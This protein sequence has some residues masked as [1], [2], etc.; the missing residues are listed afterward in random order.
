MGPQQMH[1][2]IDFSLKPYDVFLK[3]AYWRQHFTAGPTSP[4]SRWFIFSP[5]FVYILECAQSMD[6]WRL[7]Q[8]MSRGQ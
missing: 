7:C 5:F 4:M 3:Q 8:P 1:R 2:I 6:L